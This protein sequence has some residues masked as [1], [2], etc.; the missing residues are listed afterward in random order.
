MEVIERDYEELLVGYTAS[1]GEDLMFGKLIARPSIDTK[2]R[3]IEPR[4][5]AH[6]AE[7]NQ[8]TVETKKGDIE[9]IEITALGVGPHMELYKVGDIVQINKRNKVNFNEVIGRPNEVLVS[10]YDVV[11]KNRKL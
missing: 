11:V 7:G 9:L 1:S 6:K 10:H 8:H 4:A 3:L 2:S 5:F